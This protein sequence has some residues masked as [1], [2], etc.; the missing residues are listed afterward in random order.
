MRYEI[1]KNSNFFKKGINEKMNIDDC[2]HSLFGASKL[3]ADIYC[4][5]YNK[6]FGLKKGA[7]APYFFEIVC[8]F[9][10]SV[11]T[12]YLSIYLLF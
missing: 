5:E 11:E 12:M 1:N 3:A 6:Y 4:Q 8:I 9:L 2:K 7:S 10:L